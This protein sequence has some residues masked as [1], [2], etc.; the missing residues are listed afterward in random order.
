MKRTVIFN[1]PDN[2]KF[3]EYYGQDN[4]LKTIEDCGIEYGA[5]WSACDEC[6]LQTDGYA[7]HCFLLGH[8]NCNSYQKPKCPFYDGKETVNY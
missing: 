6:P 5:P 3:P 2:F 8:K 4:M 7:A 1:F